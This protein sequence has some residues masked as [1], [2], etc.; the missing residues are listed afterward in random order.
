MEPAQIHAAYDK[1]HG[2]IEERHTTVLHD[3][4]WLTG[5]RRFPGEMRLPGA[6]CLIRVT[7][8]V[9][10]AGRN[11]S[12]TRYF[13]SSRALT[14]TDAAAAVRSH[15]AIENRLHWVLD[16]TFGDDQSRLRKG[17]GAR[18]MA[19]GRHFAVNLVRTAK[20]KRSIKTRRKLAGWNTGYLNTILSSQTA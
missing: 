16:V 8:R 15:W 9:E 10:T 20:D 17:H 5:Q 6:A 2:R 19:T 13:L 14:A 18:N 1:G 3:T 7:T 4:D 11:R 12:E